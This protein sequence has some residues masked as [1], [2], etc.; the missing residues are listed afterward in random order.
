MNEG[1]PQADGGHPRTPDCLVHGAPKELPHPQAEM[2]LEPIELAAS[3]WAS[4]RAS[5][6][7]AARARGAD[8]MQVGGLRPPTETAQARLDANQTPQA[9]L[10]ANHVTVVGTRH[11]RILN[12]KRKAAP[13][14]D[15][16]DDDLQ[17]AR[18]AVF[19]MCDA[20]SSVMGL[21]AANQL[22]GNF[23][24]YKPLYASTEAL[25]RFMAEHHSTLGSLRSGEIPLRVAIEGS[26]PSAAA[27]VA[28]LRRAHTR[29]DEYVG[30]TDRLFRVLS[31]NLEEAERA[32]LQARGPAAP[33]TPRP[34]CGS[35]KPIGLSAASLHLN[36]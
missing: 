6:T 21:N 30:E 3:A 14:D 18:C 8:R 25:G 32:A 17:A 5:T 19:P 13:G 33:R 27:Y 28:S 2:A 35:L 4:E 7:E 24:D 15:D 11:F 1:V 34:A 9:R 26:W 31:H 36:E 16:E 29:I 20:T 22:C 12:G 23:V 10:D